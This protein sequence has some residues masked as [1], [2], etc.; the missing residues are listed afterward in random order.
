MSRRQD[1]HPQAVY[2][3]VPGEGWSRGT[4]SRHRTHS[5]H[6][7][8]D[9]SHPLAH[10]RGKF[11]ACFVHRQHALGWILLHER[12]AGP[13]RRRCPEKENQA[14]TVPARS[15]SPRARISVAGPTSTSRTKAGSCTSSPLHPRPGRKTMSCSTA[16]RGLPK[17]ASVP[18][19]RSTRPLT[20]RKRHRPEMEQ[21]CCGP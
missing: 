11:P 6:S 8:E 18:R 19:E 21:G 14:G 9:L 16:P 15:V 12:E 10:L 3:P 7:V 5:T 1:V 2:N 13:G 4:T 17:S 20:W